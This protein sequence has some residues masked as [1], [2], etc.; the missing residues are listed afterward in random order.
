MNIRQFENLVP[1]NSSNATTVSGSLVASNP[2]VSPLRYE[3]IQTLLTVGSTTPGFH[4]RLK[5]G[6]LLPHNQFEQHACKGTKLEA[7]YDVTDVSSQTRHWWTN[8]GV[9]RANLEITRE[10]LKQKIDDQKP[11]YDYYVQSAAAAIYSKSFDG[12]TFLAELPQAVQMFKNILKK[13]LN[14][15]KG[16]PPGTPWDLWLEGRYGWRTTIQDIINLQEVLST[17]DE[18]QKRYSERVGTTWRFQELIDLSTNGVPFNLVDLEE[19]TFEL[20]LR[21]NVTADI[22]LG[23]FSFNPIVTGWEVIRLS[24]VID[25][26]INVGQALEALSFKALASDY[27]ASWGIQ[28]SCIKNRNILATMNPGYS[29]TYVFRY[30]SD[31]QL[32]LRTPSSI[33]NSPQIKLRLS[34]LKILD[35]LALLLQQLYK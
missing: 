17:F 8:L 30:V 15:L 19:L 9:T 35:L 34:P 22:S 7:N 29:G 32:R 12:L 4:K 21:G 11:E 13:L 14:L 31:A 26:L 23:K 3:S 5:A 1:S 18:S 33:P 20:S 25:W 27:A 28:I 24:F 6:E 10:Y 16:K 2:T